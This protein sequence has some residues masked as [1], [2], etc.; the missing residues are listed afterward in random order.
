[1]NTTLKKIYNVFF[2]LEV[3]VILS[4]IFMAGQ[5]YATLG[6]NTLQEAWGGVYETKWFEAIMWLLGINLIGVMFKYKTYKKTPIF[7]LHLSIIVILIGAAITRYFGYEGTLHLRNGETKNYIMVERS[8]ANPADVYKKD[9]GFSIKLDKFVLKHYPGSMQPSSYESFIEV[10]DKNKS[11]KY[12][13]YM[14]HIL[15]YKGYR[16]YQASYDMDG[17]GSILSVNHDPGMWVAYFGYILMA[18][19]FLWSMIYKKSRFMMTVRKLKQSGLFAFLLFILFSGVNVRAFDLGEFAKKS[20]AVSDEWAKVLV[21]QRGRIEPMD[22]LDLDIV[23]K[24]T[25]KSKLYGLNYNQI[26]AGMVAYPEEFQKLP[27]IYVGHPAIRKLLGIE[28][29][30]APYNAFFMPNGDFKFTKEIDKAFK[31]PDKDRTVLDREWI[32]LNE[33]VYIAFEVYTAKIFKI[34]PTPNSKMMNYRWFSIADLQNAVKSGMMNPIDA[35]FYFNLFKNLADGIK[36]YNVELE[37][38][39]REK[40]YELQK[41]Y[42]GEILPSESRIKWEIFYNRAQIFP[43]LIGIYS[44]LGLI[45]MFLGFFEIIRQKRFKKIETLIVGLGWL[46]LILHTANMLLRW[47]ISGHAPWSDAYESIIFIAW[48]SAF[49]SVF[50]FRKSMLALGAGLFVAGMFMMV[51]HLNN[52]NPQITNLVPVLKSYWLLIHVAVITS[53][54]GFLAVGGMLGFLNLILFAMNKKYNLENQIKQLNNVIY[55]AL[56]IGLALL[57]VGTF[58]GGVWANESWGRYWS[59]DPKE[60]WSLIS[61]IVYAITIHGKMIPKLRG[62]FIFSLLSFLAFFYILFTYFG[63]NFYI[64]QGLHSYGQGVADGYGWV[65]I[66][67]AGMGAWFV[68][69]LV[70]IFMAISSKISKPVVIKEENKNNDYH[71]QGENNGM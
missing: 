53:S 34:F 36:T 49:A 4:L 16:F 19:G 42:S 13:I 18:I 70:S 33:R 46:A 56:Y 10:I 25:L 59:W 67:F 66:L 2:S 40:I 61:M 30:Y 12:H 11:F 48:G 15:V 3:A 17:K 65:N 24:L 20:K 41:T 8:K 35:Q 71:P 58:L 60:T 52:I 39:T 28:G 9:L 51:A 29:K 50:F 57:S 27:L 45:A 47:Y 43:M 64:A 62:E 37:K 1:M 6:F 23:H 44:T 69:V 32:K 14:N 55:L 7:I 31:I 63:V 38:K 5:I 22:T 26:V 21:Q 54:Y 68:V